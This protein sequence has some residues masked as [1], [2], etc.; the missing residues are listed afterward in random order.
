MPAFELKPIAKE[1]AIMIGNKEKF[2]Q[3]EA[4]LRQAEMESY[5]HETKLSFLEDPPG[6]DAPEHE[7]QAFKG[8]EAEV[9]S[10]RVMKAQWDRKVRALT[11]E[12]DRLQ[13]LIDASSA[14]SSK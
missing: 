6:D 14:S 8:V 3:I 4:Q 9:E 13:K 12:H 11:A 10:S 7:K 1:I 5:L 2:A